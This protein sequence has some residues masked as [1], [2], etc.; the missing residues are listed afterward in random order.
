[1]TADEWIA[2]A[3]AEAPELSAAQSETIRRMLAP[4][5]PAETL[6]KR[7]PV[8]QSEIRPHCVR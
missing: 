6:R 3:L 1:M 8:A 2:A 5:T 4:V 7:A